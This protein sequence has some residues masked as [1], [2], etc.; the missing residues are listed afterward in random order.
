MKWEPPDERDGRLLAS[1][2]GC[3]RPKGLVDGVQPGEVDNA[4]PEADLGT[5]PLLRLATLKRGA[6][7]DRSKLASRATRASRGHVAARPA[8]FTSTSAMPVL[9]MG[10]TDALAR[11]VVPDLCKARYLKGHDGAVVNAVRVAGPVHVASSVFM[12]S[13]TTWAMQSF[14]RDVQYSVT[15]IC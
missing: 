10:R 11:L 15:R 12:W 1:R 3:R 7:K 2:C 13:P 6:P 5:F 4:R 14:S 8:A 9:D